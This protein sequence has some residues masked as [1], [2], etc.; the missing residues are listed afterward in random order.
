MISA[1][2]IAYGSFD[3][4]HGRFLLFFRYQDNSFL[5]KILIKEKKTSAQGWFDLELEAPLGM[6]DFI[7]EVR[8][9]TKK[10]IA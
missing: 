9:K 1:T 6:N 7:G 3:L 8:Y 4:R 2:Q 10:F 5:D